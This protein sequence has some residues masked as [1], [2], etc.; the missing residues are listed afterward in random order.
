MPSPYRDWETF[1]DHKKLSEKKMEIS[2]IY[3]QCVKFLTRNKNKD[4]ITTQARNYFIVKNVHEKFDEVNP[5]LFGFK[6]GVSVEG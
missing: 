1:E 4:G 6:N 5:W 2:K 3:T